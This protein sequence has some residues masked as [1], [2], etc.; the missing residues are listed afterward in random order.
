MMKKNILLAINSLVGSVIF[1]LAPITMARA[2]VRIDLSPCQFGNDVN[3]S[4]DLAIKKEVKVN[5]GSYQDANSPAEAVNANVGDTVTWLITVSNAIALTAPE[6][7]IDVTDLLPSGVVFVSATKSAGSFSGDLWTFSLNNSDDGYESN[8]PATLEIVTTA[9]IVGTHENRADLSAYYCDG[10]CE[11]EDGNSANNFD[12]AYVNIS[13]KPQ[14]LGSSTTSTPQV[15]AAST[16][17]D[18]GTGAVVASVISGAII[19]SV[20]LLMRRRN[21]FRS[22]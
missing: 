18:T 1:A 10:P 19:L 11:Y 9:A 3:V 2:Q 4:C 21:S 8:L 17:A 20:A 6:G 13:T 14:V 5:D 15:L 12:L 16:L 7:T 22:R